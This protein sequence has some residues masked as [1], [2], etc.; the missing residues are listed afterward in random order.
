MGFGFQGLIFGG[1]VWGIQICAFGLQSLI[2][3]GVL[4][5][6]EGIEISDWIHG[7]WIG[8]GGGSD[9]GFQ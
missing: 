3:N 6:N 5:I 7:L 9:L 8:Q 1:C 4:W 2:D